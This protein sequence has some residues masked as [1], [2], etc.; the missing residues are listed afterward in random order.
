MYKI[1]LILRDKHFKKI[2]TYLISVNSQLV[3]KFK[4]LNTEN[5]DF[6]MF[7]TNIK[8]NRNSDKSISVKRQL[9]SQ[10]LT[11]QSVKINE[12]QPLDFTSKHGKT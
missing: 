6:V 7:N 11:S 5:I 2:G 10:N 1:K 4:K 9:F 3:S 12:R 8:T